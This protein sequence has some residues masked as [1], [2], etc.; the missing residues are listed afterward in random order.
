VVEVDAAGAH[1]ADVEGERGPQPVGGALEV[2]IG[3]DRE[4]AADHV[5]GLG[6]VPGR[7]KPAARAAA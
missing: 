4:R 3:D 1:A 7:A 5:E 6:R 2:V